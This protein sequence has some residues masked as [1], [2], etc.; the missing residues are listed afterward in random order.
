[1]STKK[2]RGVTKDNNLWFVKLTNN[3]KPQ[4][5]GPFETSI[6]AAFAY[7]RLAIKYRGNNTPVNFPNNKEVIEI[8]DIKSRRN[9]TEYLVKYHEEYETDNNWEESCINLNNLTK[10]YHKKVKQ[11]QEELKQIEKK[12]KQ[13]QKKR[14][15]ENN[16]DSNKMT[17]VSS[18][19]YSKRISFPSQVRNKVS[20]RQKWKCNI[21]RKLFDELFIVDHIKPLFCRGGNDTFNLQALCP[22]CDKYKTGILD[23]KIK[24]LVDNSIEIKSKDIIEMQKN[25]FFEINCFEIPDIEEYTSF[26]NSKN[27]MVPDQTMMPGQMIPNPMIPGQMI[28]NPMIPGQMMPNQMMPNQMMPNQ[29]MPGQ[30]SFNMINPYMNNVPYQPMG[31]YMQISENR[32]NNIPYS[33]SN[34]LESSKKNSNTEE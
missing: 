26:L 2:Y 34:N 6:E 28:P 7:D 21:C 23:K 13:I 33:T 17:K 9:K 24:K 27:N 12:S 30:M 18:N 1:M 29:M 32:N 8:L 5:L 19:E 20:S 22:Q 15:R 14:K 16:E 31:L 11:A 3:N 10:K 25:A 4:K